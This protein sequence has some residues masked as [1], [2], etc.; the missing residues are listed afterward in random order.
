M[1]FFSTYQIWQIVAYCDKKKKAC[2]GYIGINEKARL[3]FYLGFRL[4]GA[5]S[6]IEVLQKRD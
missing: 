3:N 1:F 2:G 5:M 6:S 4:K